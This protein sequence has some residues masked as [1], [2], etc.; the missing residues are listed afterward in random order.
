MYMRKRPLVTLLSLLMA[1]VTAMGQA[2][3]Q[4]KA[5]LAYHEIQDLEKAGNVIYVQASDNLYAYNTNDNSVQTFSKADCLNDCQ[6]AHIKYNAT[7]KKLVIVYTNYNIDL[8]ADNG[9]AEILTD[10]QNNTLAVDKTVNDI[11][12]NGHL[13]YLST[14]FGIVKLNVKDA[15]ISDTYNLGFPVNYT[16]IE[17]DHIYAASS[18]AGLYQASLTANLVDKSQ[19]SRVGDYTPKQP[20]D[21]QDLREAVKNAN[22]GGPWYNDFYDMKYLYNRL[23]AC[24][25]GFIAGMFNISNP[26]GVQV[27][28]EGEWTHTQENLQAITGYNCINTNCFAIDPHDPTHI[29]TGDQTGV[30][31]YKDGT[32]INL[33]NSDNSPLQAVIDGG[34]QLD[35][36]Y[37]MINGMTFDK[38]GTLWILNG[39]TVSNSIFSYRDGQFISHHQQALE[40]ADNSS[41]MAGLSHAFMDSEGKLWFVNYHHNETSFH[42]YDT[43]NNILTAY[44]N[45]LQNQNGESVGGYVTCIA[46][47][48]DGNMWLGT[49]LGVYYQSPSQ[50]NET[51]PVVL[52]QVIVPRNDGSNLGDYLLSGANIS[53][54]AIDAANRKWI[55][56]KGTGLYVI[57]SD[58][59]TEVHHFTEGNSPL[60]SN[61]VFSLAINNATGEVFIGTDKGLCSYMSEAVSPSEEMTKDNVY[62]YPN[63]VRPGY[64]GKITITGLT[65]DADVKITSSNGSLVH[66]GRSTAGTYQW[67][68]CDKNGKPVASGIYMVQTATA[69]GKKGTVCKIA[70]VR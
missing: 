47:D 52:T 7:A 2:F 4:W 51:S 68:G 63:P 41:T 48:R 12:M 66:Q 27:M 37:M 58:N 36:N 61:T 69:N 8:L 9:E 43:V 59:T 5:Y 70:I 15:E 39:Q 57:D 23:Y 35:N 45:N 54:I 18:S 32:F 6:I 44:K 53:C 3:G 42:C 24:G 46:E 55:G 30:Y 33:Y 56:T 60:L 22:P 21:K 25:G 29:F 62:A 50:R 38:E 67:D 34:V 64:A 19:W 26:G 49:T 11:Y 31:E 65:M 40:L 1:C 14:G 28:H 10:Y 16:Y 17:G 20:E 13:A